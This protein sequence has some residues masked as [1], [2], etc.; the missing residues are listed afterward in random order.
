MSTASHM[1][2]RS[3][4]ALLGL[5]GV[6]AACQG[7]SLGWGV[8][9]SLDGIAAKYVQ[10]TLALAQHQ[11]SLV[12]AWRGPEGWR[13]QARRPI[14][15]ILPDVRDLAQALSDADRGSDGRFRWRYLSGQIAALDLV[16]RRLAGETTR[17]ADEAHEMLGVDGTALVADDTAAAAARATVAQRL[18]GRAPLHERLAAFR[19]RH[20]I[21]PALVLPAF[22]AAVDACRD[23]VRAHVPMPAA[24]R[25]DVEAGSDLDAEARAAY[26]GHDRTTVT[27]DPAGSLDLA[28]LV[29]VAAH[30][31]Y[32]GH[33][34]QHVLADRD[35]VTVHGWPE[36]LLAPTFGPHLLYA[37]GG[38]DAGAGLLLEGAAFEEVCQRAGAQSGAVR[39]AVADVVAVQRAVIELDTAIPAIARAYLDGDIGSE[40]AIE[41]LTSEALIPEASRVLSAIERRRSRFLVYP[42]GRRLVARALDAAPPQERWARLASIATYLQL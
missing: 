33:H 8:E 39:G 13:P 27:I 38:A 1:S 36:R 20:V 35:V 23:R 37:E 32:P 25:V 28:R 30:E 29:W 16:V 22:Q 21:A 12:E 7:V 42:I 19:K 31:T 4:L 11:P 14:G 40:A 10:L 5:A 2:R 24:E 3:T 18:P 26:A 34:V 6:S 9:T 15:E 41:R 17:L